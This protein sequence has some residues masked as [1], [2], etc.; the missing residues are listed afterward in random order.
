MLPKPALTIGVEEE[1]LLVDRD[2][3]DL[4]DDPPPEFMA[5][6]ERRL[7]S[8][9]TGEFLKAQVEIG[10]GICSTIQE[11]RSELIELRGVVAEVANKFDMAPIAASTHPFA[12]WRKQHHTRAERYDIL[13]QDLQA[14]V[15]RLLICGM[16]VH[17]GIEEEDMRIDLMNQASY[18]LP[19]LLALSTSSPFWVG[20]K[21]GLMSYR[22]TVFDSLPRTGVPERFDSFG[23]YRRLVNQLVRAGMIEDGSKIWWDLRP[24]S[25][26]PTLEMRMTDVCTRLEDSLTIA[27]FYQCIMSMLYRLRSLNQRWRTYPLLCV[28]ENRWRA[29]RY[30][31]TDTMIDFG[32]G[33]QV[34]YSELLSEITELCREDAE[35]LDCVA[36]IANAQQIVTN[37]SSA[38]MQ[39]KVY[40]EAIEQGKNQDDALKA[41]V[42]WLIETTV[43]GLN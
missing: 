1:Y 14:V 10:T 7:G 30:G 24:S 5:E 15:R 4:A 11:A 17:I 42:D 8:R 20:E 39:L 36:E 38:Q 26:F 28:Q 32:I 31:T 23:E 27:A 29:Q 22:L 12:T 43:E 34:P 2:S 33:E 25:K 16:H 21:T 40:D 37:G 9:V 18:F 3:R 13:A 6:C 35:R 19:H 41:V